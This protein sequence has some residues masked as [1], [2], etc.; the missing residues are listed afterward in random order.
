MEE[1]V[2]PLALCKRYIDLT[3][4]EIVS[5]RVRAAARAPSFGVRVLGA[6]CGIGISYMQP[7]RLPGTIDAPL[8]KATVD[9]LIV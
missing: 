1:L 6:G 2:L 4:D 5:T 3:C 7:S 8:L 9:R